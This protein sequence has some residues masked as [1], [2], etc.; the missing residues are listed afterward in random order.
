VGSPA[1]GPATGEGGMDGLTA[2]AAHP[3]INMKN[4]VTIIKYER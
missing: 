4:A 2:G 1:G 3:A